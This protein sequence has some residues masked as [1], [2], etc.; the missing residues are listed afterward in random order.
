MTD[1]EKKP[2]DAESKFSGADLAQELDSENQQANRQRL[3]RVWAAWQ[4]VKDMPELVALFDRNSEQPAGVNPVE[5]LAE[6]GYPPRS[7]IGELDLG[8]WTASL[9]PKFVKDGCMYLLRGDNPS[10]GSKGFYSR[11]YG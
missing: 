1:E 2:E 3:D 6:H 8:E 11:T 5:L 4:E 10:Q 7:T 9:D